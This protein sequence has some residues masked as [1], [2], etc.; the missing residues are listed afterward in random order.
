MNFDKNKYLEKLFKLTI[1]T[2]FKEIHSI[3]EE[4]GFNPDYY[5]IMIDTGGLSYTIKKIAH[6]LYLSRRPIDDTIRQK[7]LLFNIV[8]ETSVNLANFPRIN[9]IIKQE[10]KGS[11]SFNREA[12]KKSKLITEV[13]KNVEQAYRNCYTCADYPNGCGGEDKDC[14]T[15][16][17]SDWREPKR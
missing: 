11:W 1:G 17:Y 16:D 2:T 15:P 5:T 3:C 4:V 8:V 9:D 10:K 6:N 14:C 12:E 7:L 13:L